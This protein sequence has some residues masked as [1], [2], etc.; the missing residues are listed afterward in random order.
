[1]FWSKG[2]INIFGG[3]FTKNMASEG[4]GV[5]S[6]SYGSTTTLAGGLFENNEASNGGVITSGKNS[7]VSVGDGDF[8]G[9]VAQ[10]DG[11]V[12]MVDEGGNIEVGEHNVTL[13]FALAPGLCLGSGRRRFRIYIPRQ[14]GEKQAQAH[15]STRPRISIHSEC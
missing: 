4:G 9:N 14:I 2:E 6:A 3:N 7:N 10:N 11:G 8:T 12:F 15:H 5:I 13:F 1:M